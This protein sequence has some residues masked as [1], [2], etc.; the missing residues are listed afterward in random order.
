MRM[1]SKDEKEIVL[2]YIDEMLEIFDTVLIDEFDENEEPNI[3]CNG[4]RFLKKDFES[5]KLKINLSS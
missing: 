2:S 5:L 1:F 3:F 4:R